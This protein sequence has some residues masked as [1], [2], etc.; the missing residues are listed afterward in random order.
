MAASTE[1]VGRMHANVATPSPLRQ[2]NLWIEQAGAALTGISFPCSQ[3][4]LPYEYRQLLAEKIA[5]KL[6][7]VNV[8]APDVA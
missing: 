5:S 6:T 3:D 4:C 1:F 8:P 2:Y 7:R